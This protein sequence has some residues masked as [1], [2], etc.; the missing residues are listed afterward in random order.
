MTQQ[1]I[2]I[3]SAEN[4][5]TG[6][7]LRSAFNAVNENF[8][9]VWAAGPVDSNVVIS[10][11][12]IT[13]NGINNNLVLA[14]NGIGNIQANSTIMPSIDNVY[15]IGGPTKRVNTVY[16]GYFVGDG[17]LLT[18]V[19]GGGNGTA[20]ANGTSNVQVYNNGNVTIG[21]NNTSNV[22]VVSSNLAN[23]NG[24]LNALNLTTPGAV[25]AVGNITGGNLKATGAIFIGN[26][27][28]T[29]TLTVGTRTSPVTVPLATNNSFNVGT[30]SSGNVVVY[31]T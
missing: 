19:G 4:D 28:L 7:A 26:T 8:T 23:V 17:S 15:D 24:N 1:I 6:E 11:N 21:I 22:V 9:A 30:R 25:T 13:V 5:G 2:N 14:A 16:A 18:N 10:G 12:T 29:R 31:T 3:G 20:I 27:A